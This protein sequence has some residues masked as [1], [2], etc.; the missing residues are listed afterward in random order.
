M[1]GF[2]G[3]KQSNAVTASKVSCV[4]VLCVLRQFMGHWQRTLFQVLALGFKLALLNQ[5]PNVQVSKHRQHEDA[6]SVRRATASTSRSRTLRLIVTRTERE[7]LLCA[8][9][10]VQ[11]CML[12]E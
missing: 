2:H 12:G 4:R 11:V 1:C 6:A 9:V 7:Q 3:A 8:S 5:L 10:Q